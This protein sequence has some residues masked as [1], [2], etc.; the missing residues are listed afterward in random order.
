MTLRGNTPVQEKQ[1]LKAFIYGPPGMGKT[2]AGLQ[3]PNAYIIDTAKETSR[4]WKLIQQKN[5]VVFNCTDPY[6]VI[7]ELKILKNESHRFQTLIIDEISTL[8]SNLQKLWTDRFIKAQQE[9]SSKHKQSE[10]ENLL[11]DFGYR[12]WDKVKR[13]WKRLLDLLKELDMNVI[14]NAHEKSK[15][16][17]SQNIIGVTSDSDKNDEYFWDFV[18]RLIKRGQEYKAITEKQRILPVEIDPKAKR[19]PKEFIWDYP[20]LLKFYNKEYIEKPTKNSQLYETPETMANY[21]TS[22]LDKTLEKSTESKKINKT[23]EKENSEKDEE[24]LKQSKK[25]TSKKEEKENKKEIKKSEDEKTTTFEATG[26]RTNNKSNIKNNIDKIKELLK[27]EEI[28]IK[29]FK[30][31][32]QNTCKW[33]HVNVLAKLSNKEQDILLNGWKNKI[34]PKFKETIIKEKKE[35]EI[36]KEIDEETNKE[37]NEPNK[38]IE[39][40][41]YPDKPIRESQKEKI[42]IGLQKEGIELK[43]FFDGFMI[44]KW[45]EISQEGAKNMLLNL[46]TMIGA[47]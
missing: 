46:K 15:Y 23:I 28:S 3:F 24:K 27:E 40:I 38:E 16:G 31:F 1:K 25:E 8:Y 2:I 17:S 30:I 29:D 45:E 33:K 14:V 35:K 10:N 42:L 4:Y 18:F 43:R 9:R 34:I 21:S 47:L 26:E 12:Y 7:K 20:N 39:E 11:E 19:F 13:D 36:K 37:I 41:Y 5:S 22:L 44:K 32:L 6:E